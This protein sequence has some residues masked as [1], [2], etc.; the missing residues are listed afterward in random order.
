[1]YFLRNPLVVQ[2]NHHAQAVCQPGVILLSG[3]NEL[4]IAIFLAINRKI[5]RQRTGYALIQYA[6]VEAFRPVHNDGRTGGVGN[7]RISNRQ[8]FEFRV[9][10]SQ[11]R[12][13]LQ[14]NQRPQVRRLRLPE[15][16]CHRQGLFRAPVEAIH[17]VG[18]AIPDIAVRRFTERINFSAG[19]PGV[20]G[21]RFQRIAVEARKAAFSADPD[22][23]PRIFPKSAHLLLGE[24]VADGESP[25]WAAKRLCPTHLRVQAGAQEQ[26]PGYADSGWNHC[27]K[28]RRQ[29]QGWVTV[30][31]LDLTVVGGNMTVGGFGLVGAGWKGVGL[32]K[33]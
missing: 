30:G 18:G 4:A 32:W 14:G 25:A 21:K 12:R 3:F 8:T 16:R 2:A 28:I 1:M 7:Q 23:S 5:R 9:T 13:N 10:L 26:K 29:W 33:E 27:S 20:S 17:R 19:K 22:V 31:W 15:L 11:Q 24:S 6:V